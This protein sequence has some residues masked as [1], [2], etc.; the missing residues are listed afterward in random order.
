MEASLRPFALEVVKGGRPGVAQLSLDRVLASRDRRHVGT[1]GDSVLC[2]LMRVFSLVGTS[3][4]ETNRGW[5]PCLGMK[6]ILGWESEA[7]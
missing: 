2:P 7:A 4:P 3:P 5:H 1:T 6:R